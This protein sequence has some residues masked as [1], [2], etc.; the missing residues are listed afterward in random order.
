MKTKN[1]DEAVLHFRHRE[2]RLSDLAHYLEKHYHENGLYPGKDVLLALGMQTLTGDGCVDGL[3]D[4]RNISYFMSDMDNWLTSNKA[5]H[6]DIYGPVED[7]VTFECGECGYVAK[8]IDVS[9][10]Q[11]CPHCGSIFA[12]YYF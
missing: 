1:K 11:F 5:E 2:D 7:G 3:V 6:P 8:D 10:W 9:S 12:P 4:Y